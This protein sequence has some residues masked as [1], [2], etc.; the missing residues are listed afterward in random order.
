MYYLSFLLVALLASTSVSTPAEK[1]MEKQTH[2]SPSFHFGVKTGTILEIIDGGKI[3]ILDDDSKW[4]VEPDDINY[5]GGW[6][7]P[8]PVRVKKDGAPS[9]IFNYSMTNT[10]TKKTVRVRKWKKKFGKNKV[11]PLPQA[12][13]PAP[14]TPVTSPSPHPV[15]KKS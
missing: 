5:T 6:L 12:Q 10:W 11:V 14:S 13:Q 2:A 1:A 15:E 9:E 8:A 7:G 3:I 4:L